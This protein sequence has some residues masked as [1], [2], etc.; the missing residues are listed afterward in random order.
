V[1]RTGTAV[2]CGAVGAGAIGTAIS[3]AAAPCGGCYNHNC[4][5]SGPYPVDGGVLAPSANG[6]IEWSS[7]PNAGPWLD[8]PG[9]RSYIFNYPV[10]FASPPDLGC[11]VS[12]DADKPQDNFVLCGGNLVQFFDAGTTS[13][14]VFNPSCADYG[15][16]L[17]ATGV[18]ATAD[19]GLGVSGQDS[20]S[21]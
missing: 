3:M 11:R 2:A 15:L 13:V 8:F 18:P 4:D 7:G 14:G 20:G 6:Q 10:A 21:E 1:R 12:A 17:T 5:P 9:Q 19:G 16:I